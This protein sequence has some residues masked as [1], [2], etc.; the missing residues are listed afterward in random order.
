[1]PHE[2]EEWNMVDVP[3][4]VEVLKERRI[5]VTTEVPVEID[6]PVEID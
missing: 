2:I 5:P 3:V 4:E 6:I 1:V